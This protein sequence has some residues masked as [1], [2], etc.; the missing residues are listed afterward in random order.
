M[1]DITNLTVILDA[2][3]V[4]AMLD[5]TN[6]TVMLDATSVAAMLD[7]TTNSYVRCDKCSS[8]VICNN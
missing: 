4:A 2:T 6:L 8:Y 3:S 1:L 7:V 5:I